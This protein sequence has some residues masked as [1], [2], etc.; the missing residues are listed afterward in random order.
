M[1]GVQDRVMSVHAETAQ[2]IACRP[3]H[4]STRGHEVATVNGYPVRQRAALKFLTER[5]YNNPRPFYG[6]EQEATWARMISASA[7][8]MSRL[9]Y[10]VNLQEHHVSREPRTGCLEGVAGYLKLYYRG[11]TELPPN[12]SNGNLPVV[13]T[14]E[15][16][17]HS[18][19]VFDE[20]A[21]RTGNQEYAEF[22]DQLRRLIEQDTF[23]KR[24][25]DVRRPVMLDLCY[26]TA[27][28]VQID[29]K[30]YAGRIKENC[31]WILRLQRPDG[32][33]SMLLDPASEAVRF[34]TGHSLWVLALAGYGPDHPQV[35]KGVLALLRS[36][37]PW[38]GWLDSST[39]ENFR[40]PFRETQF[41]VM[42]LSQLFPNEDPRRGPEQARGWQ[43]GFAPLP[44]RLNLK[45]ESVLL[46]QL[47]QV[48][49]RPSDALVAQVGEALKHPEV[50]VRQAAAEAAGRVVAPELL[51]GVARLLGDPSKVVRHSA[52]WALRE[53]A[54]RSG[55]GYEELKS[56][57]ASA[58][59]VTR[60]GAARVF[61]QHFAYLT[62]DGGLGRALLGRLADPDPQVRLLA[63]RG[64]WQWF[65]W[66]KDLGLRGEIVDALL[67]RMGVER[68][69]YV[70]RNLREALYNV[71]DENTRYLFNNWVPLLARPADRDQATKA[72]RA[73][74]KMIADRVARGLSGPDAALA[75]NVLRALGEFHLRRGG[76]KNAGRYGRIGNDIEQIQFY[77]DSLD[78]LE[79]PLLKLLGHAD[80]QVRE[81]A[82]VAAYT[83]RGAGAREL[84]F[85]WLELYGDSSPA[86]RAAA[87]ELQPAFPLPRT[88]GAAQRVR[89]SLS[90]LLSSPHP[91]AQA[92]ALRTAG[93]VAGLDKDEQLLAAVRQLVVSADGQRLPAAL[94][95]LPQFPALHGDKEVRA[96]VVA[97]LQSRDGAARRAALGATLKAPALAADKAVHF[98]LNRL[99]RSEAAADRHALFEVVR[100]DPAL[101]ANLEVVSV[102]SEALAS[103]DDAV[104][105]EA[106]A[107]VQ[108]H[109]P[110]RRN[111][112]VR[113]AL[114][115]L[116][117]DPG[118]RTRQLAEQYYEG[119]G[120]A[121]GRADVTRL[122][123]YD[124][125]VERV[126]PLLA[127]AGADGQACVLCHH[128]HTIFR[129]SRP[130]PDGRFSAEQSQLHYRSALKVIDLA[131]P[132]ESLLLRK[133]LSD[134]KS[135]GVIDQKTLSHG[136]GVRWQG[137]EDPAYRTLLA[138][139]NGAR[140]EKPGR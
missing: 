122:L 109:A 107:L 105:R 14:Y 62:H 28:L 65:W 54:T 101:A 123:D 132:E 73:Q 64:A 79:P 63:A 72:Q 91:E 52:A 26:Q 81:H 67:G 124:Y 140:L 12:E 15:V 93:Q 76:Y 41:A 27:D 66:T 3:T 48:W 126:Q 23:R 11:R 80:P 74:M 69:P 55:Q 127:R 87:A 94:A 71:A 33:W 70:L 42:A 128:T 89:A 115:A 29:P 138:W 106:L 31:E 116:L 102:V 117:S 121:A 135:E 131:R 8:V 38:G 119:K 40:T 59:E 78:A 24:K 58:D 98:Y 18:W 2:C 37:Q 46:A 5:L 111:P 90:R 57:L 35:R 129:L 134:A 130:G 44:E 82:A 86:V 136:G 83:L 6:H 17:G 25:D 95:A 75:D 125:F 19:V 20:L 85:R 137:T 13:S 7:N 51:P 32:Q 61:T 84:P 99:L 22:R 68:H 97:A 96:A 30:A 4:F 39:Y 139:I 114:K 133:P 9:A 100:A 16:A 104:R 118:E 21:R 49:E 45:N 113:L 108:K 34:Q 1:G 112:A 50:L 88:A 60:R 120:K 92:A 43:A 53:Y 110:M 36:R 47:D 103:R 77:A 10:L 56:A